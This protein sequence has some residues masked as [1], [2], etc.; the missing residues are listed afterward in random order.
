M[1]RKISLSLLVLPLLLAG[2]SD[3]RDAL[4]LGRNTPDEFV[5][6]DRAPLVMPPDFALRPPQPGAPR[7]Q[8]AP[9]NAQAEAAVFGTA[10]KDQPAVADSLEKQ[11]LADAGAA[12]A[13][14]GIRKTVDRESA[15][16]SSR[17]LVDDLLWWRKSEANGTALD[18]SA[19]A[20]RLKRN[21]AAGKPANAGAT[22]APTIEP[23]KTGWLGF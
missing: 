1:T 21:Q 22:P 3:T 20:E 23:R 5:V 15:D 16:T 12:K 19:E 18:A 17:H 4:G 13:A 14:P 6:V 9:T 11:V 2:C 10:D 8:E 7:P